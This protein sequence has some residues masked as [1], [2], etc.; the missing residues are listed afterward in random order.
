MLQSRNLDDQSFEQIMEY[1]TGRLPWLCP[2]WT[3]YNAHDPGITILELI[4]WYKEMQQYHM[5]TVTPALQKKLLKLLGVVPR[6]PRPAS[7]LVS[8]PGTG[9]CRPWPGWRAPRGSALSFWSRPSR[10][11]GW[12]PPIWRAAAACRR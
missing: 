2:A 8:P 5:N 1:V 9:G 4:A 7:C 3:D 11:A 12:R 6:P 10:R